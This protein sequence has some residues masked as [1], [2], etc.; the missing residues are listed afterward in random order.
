MIRAIWWSVPLFGT[1]TPGQAPRAKGRHR[2]RSIA[3]RRAA[4]LA[5]LV[6]PLA[7]GQLAAEPFSFIVLDDV[8]YAADEEYD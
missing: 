7:I 4:V 1:R 6:A 2:P 8:H 3:R 5:C